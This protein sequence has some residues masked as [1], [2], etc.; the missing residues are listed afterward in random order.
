MNFLYGLAALILTVVVPSLAAA[1]SI[2]VEDGDDWGTTTQNR[3]LLMRFAETGR[4]GNDTLYPMNIGQRF[5]FT[6]TPKSSVAM[7]PPVPGG[8]RDDSSARVRDREQAL[9]EAVPEPA[10]MLLFGVG[11]VGLA[12]YLRKGRRR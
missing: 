8:E 1:S 4:Q 12:S 6:A 7:P 10:T 11:L 5:A 9:F 3:Y 2:L